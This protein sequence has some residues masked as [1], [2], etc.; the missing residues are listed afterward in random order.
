MWPP[1]ERTETARDAIEQMMR[2]AGL[3]RRFEH[4]VEREARTAAKGAW[5]RAEAEVQEGRRRDLRDL[6][7]FTVDPSTARDFDDAISAERLADGNV[8]V[9]V[10][11]ADVAAHI[12]AGSLVD[13]EARR[14][15]TSVYV[16]GAVEPMLPHALSSDACSLVPGAERLAVTVE[17]VLRGA[18]VESASFCRSLIRSDMRLDY[19]Q[20][21]RIFAGSEPAPEP[22]GRPLVAARSAAAALQQARES[23]GALVI[24][25]EEPEFSFDEHGNVLEIVPRAQ[26]ESHRL[27][28][29]LMIAANEAVARQLAQASVP[30]LYRIH[31][32]PDP[33]RIRRLV[34][35]LASLGVSTPPLPDPLL[36]SRAAEFVG[37]ISRRVDGHVRGTGCGRIALSS[38][39]L[40]SLKQ[41]CYSP[42]NVGHAGLH[43]P[44][45]CHFTSPI[46]RY[47]DLVCHRA[48]LA[49][50]GAG[51]G[52]GGG[53]GAGAGDG[54]GESRG[55]ARKGIGT[56]KLVGGRKLVELG[57]WTSE[58][59]REAAKL[60][61]KG[62]DIAAC[63]L[64]EQV[65]LDGG[66]EQVF[67]GEVTGLIGAGAFIVFGSPPT[68][69]PRARAQEA[70][71]R[72]VEVASDEPLE[73]FRERPIYEGMLP[74]RLLSAGEERDWWEL[75]EQS[76]ILR[77]E[78]SGATLRLGDSVDVRVVRVD[79]SAGRVDLAPAG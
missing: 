10:H 5:H 63:F 12:A 11:I 72:T 1:Q 6:P 32:R 18:K 22:W 23:S 42:K 13:Q 77:G 52:V 17:L 70:N 38:L 45:Y 36:P 50:I 57:E 51:D 74:V 37:E 75:N 21:D 60:E 14:R 67:E 33:E 59:E 9:W 26:T 68:H 78:R 41:A 46:R 8:R 4:A 61:H 54:V 30:C 62:D 20:V 34:A 55:A 71:E 29:H 24:S 73:E 76:T 35:Q 3:A 2:E 16:P 53:K 44:C 15:A 43:S 65:L 58:R 47:P 39:V 56:G 69:A 66:Y 40:R 7:T 79:A 31:E 19:E 49:S 48:L 27:I 64:L 28:E 25:T